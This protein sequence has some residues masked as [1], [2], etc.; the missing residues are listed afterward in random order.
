MN[1]KKPIVGCLFFK[2]RDNC[3]HPD[4]GNDCDF[5]NCPLITSQARASVADLESQAS[6]A[7]QKITDLQ[8]GLTNGNPT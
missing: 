1:I 3:I 4:N 8:E 7:N 6:A 2:P 5:N